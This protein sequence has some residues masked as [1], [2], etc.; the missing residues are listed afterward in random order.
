MP[1]EDLPVK[2]VRTMNPEIQ[3]SLWRFEQ[4]RHDA[5]LERRRAY[6]QARRP[7]RLLD[8]TVVVANGSEA[9]HCPDLAQA[10]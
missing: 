8:P 6:L 10:S 1:V 5:E 7:D 3:Y 2:G 9:P 4:R